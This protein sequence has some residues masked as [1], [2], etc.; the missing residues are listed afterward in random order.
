M[1]NNPIIQYTSR[2]Y[3]TIKND[4]LQN[5]YLRDKPQWFLELMAALGDVV[6]MWENASANQNRLR[7]SFTRQATKDLLDLIDYTLTQQ[8]TSTGTCIFFLTGGFA[9]FPITFTDDQLSALSSGSVN[10]SSKRFEARTGATAILTTGNFIWSGT[11]NILTVAYDFVYTGHKVRFTTTNTLPTGLSINTDYYII[12][13]SATQ[14]QVATSLVNA[15]AG[16]VVAITGAGTGTHT[17]TLYSFTK[18]MYQQESIDSQVISKSDGITKFQE[19]DFPDK[20]V[21][22]STILITIGGVSYTNVESLVNSISTDKHWELIVKSEGY[23]GCRFGDGTYGILPPA[24][25]II[26]EYAV[27]GGSNSNILTLNKINI[28]TGGSSDIVGIFNATT[29]TGAADEEDL[30]LAKILGPLLLKARDRFVTQEDGEALILAYGGISL[31]QVQKNTYGP[32]SCQILGVANGGGNPSAGIRTAIETYLIDKSILESI[33][34]RFNAYTPKTVIVTSATK[35]LPGYT[36]AIISPYITLAWKIFT[37]ETGKEI[38]D[39]Y[40]SSGINSAIDLI[41]TIFS[42]SF[43]YSE[44]VAIGKIIEQL[45][46]FGYRDFG[47]TIQEDDA[48]GFIRA[49]VDGI[50][51]MTITLPTFPLIQGTPEILTNVGSTYSLTEI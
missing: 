15:L 36:W 32:L 3:L 12:R 48:I 28:Y 27:G 33:D 47:D 26:V 18:T 50:D 8:I 5:P 38:I 9:G 24:N 22:L 10:T 29:F 37:S 34:I 31:V 1:P 39:K 4:I 44:Y 46:T 17:W 51:Y 49:A 2:T 6:S 23:S 40:I 45:D 35:V 42:T 11:G 20:N 21:I 30:E 41:N 7:T 13:V 25:D 43:T 19:F 14:I 16:T